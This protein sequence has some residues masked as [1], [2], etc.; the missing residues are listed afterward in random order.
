MNLKSL[1]VVVLRL[2]ALN[3]LFSLFLTFLPG[4]AILFQFEA[5]HADNS[6]FFTYLLFAAIFAAVI[7]ISAGVWRFAP[8]L[9]DWM[10]TGLDLNIEI[11]GFSMNDAYTLGFLLLGLYFTIGR[12]PKFFYWAWTIFHAVT[13]YSGSSWKRGMNFYKILSDAVPFALGL[14]MIVKARG[15]GDCLNRFHSLDD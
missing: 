4:I 8:K 13:S 14:A 7:A 9:A 10:T 2:F 5:R 1:V 3:V 6:T 15:W 12:C 11:D